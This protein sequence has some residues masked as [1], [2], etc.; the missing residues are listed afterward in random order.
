MLSRSD[1]CGRSTD[2]FHSVLSCTFGA[3]LERPVCARVFGVRASCSGEGLRGP[4]LGS[5]GVLDLTDA[6]GEVFPWACD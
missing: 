3:V 6:G 2:D 5:G 1:N 4:W